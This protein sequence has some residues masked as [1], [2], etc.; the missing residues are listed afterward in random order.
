MRKELITEEI[1]ITP[2]ITL[3]KD[4]CHW[5]VMAHKSDAIFAMVSVHTK[6][7]MAVLLEKNYRQTW[8][9]IGEPAAAER[10]DCHDVVGL[11]GLYS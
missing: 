3:D 11:K 5:S 6:T 8:S 10:V 7:R 4:R 9:C 2:A 1:R